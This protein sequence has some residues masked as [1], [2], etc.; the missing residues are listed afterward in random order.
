M[1]LPTIII[2]ALIAAVFIAIVVRGIVNRRRG[3]GGCS[4]GCSGCSGCCPTEREKR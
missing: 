2:A 1:N 3:R 4:C